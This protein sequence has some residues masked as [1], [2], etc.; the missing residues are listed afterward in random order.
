MGIIRLTATS[1]KVGYAFRLSFLGYGAPIVVEARRVPEEWVRS[2]LRF[3]FHTGLEVGTRR[4]RA[5]AFG[6][7]DE[8]FFCFAGADITAS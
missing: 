8:D 4:R 2:K 6:K 1:K 5:A 3:G 7:R